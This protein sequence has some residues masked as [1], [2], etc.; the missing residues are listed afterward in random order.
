MAVTLDEVDARLKNIEQV[1]DKLADVLKAGVPRAPSIISY[2]LTA[3]AAN[4]PYNFPAYQPVEPVVI[5]APITNSGIIYIG[6]NRS[7][8]QSTGRSYPLFPGETVTY[9]IRSLD[10]LWYL[11]T[12]ASEGLIWTTESMRS[13]K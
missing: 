7:D 5:K 11:S 10:E 2:K 12:V 6:N 3:T 8:V 13:N 1:L 4:E 9:N